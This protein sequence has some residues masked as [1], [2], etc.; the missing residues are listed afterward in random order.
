MVEYRCPR[1]GRVVEKPRGEYYCRVCGPNFR[2]E[3]F[4]DYL[5]IVLEFQS[6]EDA[7]REGYIPLQSLNIGGEL[8][9]G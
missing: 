2:M 6:L 3:E 5:P 9:N 1:C 4:V 8:E 7:I